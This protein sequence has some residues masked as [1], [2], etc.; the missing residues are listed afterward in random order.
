MEWRDLLGEKLKFKEKIIFSFAYTPDC[1][2]D[3]T[4]KK[5]S[6]SSPLYGVKENGIKKPAVVPFFC[7]RIYADMEI[8]LTHA[9]KSGRRLGAGASR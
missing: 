8:T 6:F 4:R 3:R 5:Q 9:D 1:C 7:M 2:R